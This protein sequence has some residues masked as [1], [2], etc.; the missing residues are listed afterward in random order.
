MTKQELFS[1]LGEKLSSFPK[2]EIEKSFEFYDEIINDH[3]DD[4]KTEEEAV[5]ALGAVGDI[6]ADIVQ[7]ISLPCLLKSS[8][9][10]TRPKSNHK[11]LWIALIIIGSVVWIPLLLAALAILLSV[12]IVIWATAI[13][14]CCVV[15]AFG[16]S[17]LAFL[18]GSILIISAHELSVVLLYLAAA[19]VCIGICLMLIKPMVLFIKKLAVFTLFVTKKIKS[20]FIPRREKE[21]EIK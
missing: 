5:A 17:G 20:L 6:M 4:G 18:V 2:S 1:V 8:L 9:N 3:I 14:V 13:T 11:A 12:Y 15:L 7:G 19:L 16:L 21:N 10:K